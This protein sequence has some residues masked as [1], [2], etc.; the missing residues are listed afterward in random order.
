LKISSV[1]EIASVKIFEVQVSEDELDVYESC[2]RY[3]YENLE[4]VEEIC[5][6]SKDELLGMCEDV[7]N[8]LEAHTDLRPQA[9]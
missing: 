7:S 5:G 2:M 9:Q 8:L 4:N 3:I 6:A 1:R